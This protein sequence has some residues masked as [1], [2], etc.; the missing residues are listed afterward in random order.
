MLSTD[1]AITEHGKA[2]RDLGIHPRLA[3]MVLRGRKIGFGQAAA[4]LA[5]LLGERDLLG[6]S[7][8]ADMHER[9][10]VLRGATSQHRV[11]PARLKSIRQDAQRLLVK[12]QPAD[13][14]PSASDTGRLLALAYPDR[15][16][17]RRSG[18]SARYQLSNGKG[19]SLREDDALVRYDWLVAADLDGKTRQATIYLAAPVNLTDIEQDLSALITESEE[20]LW[21]I[22]RHVVARHVRKLGE[23]V[24]SEKNYATRSSIDSA[25]STQCCTKNGLH[26]LH[27]TDS[28]TSGVRA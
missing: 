8:G 11:E 12:I 13:N 7:A 21:M 20:A 3:N 1:G 16:G 23:L 2:A 19:A 6:S 15:I 25:R 14:S 17:Q 10:Q 24:L 27:W 4:E 18:Q 26:A 5:A 9:L 28:A 22:T